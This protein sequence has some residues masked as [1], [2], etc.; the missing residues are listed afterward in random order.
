MKHLRAFITFS[1]SDAMENKHFIF[2]K[3]PESRARK[4]GR[5]ER[6]PQTPLYRSNTAAFTNVPTPS[7]ENHH[8]HV[9]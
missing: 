5:R 8:V 9:C 7:C 4:L 3:T 6:E 1:T 2:L